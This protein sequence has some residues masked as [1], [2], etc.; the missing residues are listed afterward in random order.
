MNAA[1]VLCLP[2]R[3]E[4]MPNV[5]LEAL[6]SGLP[7]V[8]SDAGNCREIV[9]DEPGARVAIPGDTRAFAAGLGELLATRLDRQALMERHR[10]KYSW[11]RQADSI[12]DAMPDLRSPVVRPPL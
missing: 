11:R 8:V 9:A 4:G 5:A 1:D 6:V 3:S 7:L 2:S 12:L 10:A